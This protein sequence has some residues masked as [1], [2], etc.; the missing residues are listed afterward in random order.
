MNGFIIAIDGHSSCGKS[1]LAR[2]LAGELKDRDFVFIDSGAMYRAVTLYF[3][4]NGIAPGD[5]ERIREALAAIQID[6]LPEAESTRIL[7][8][9]EDVSDAIRQMRVSEK[10][11][12]VSAVREVRHAM[13]ARQ[14]QLGQSR[15]IVMD[16]AATSARPYSRTPI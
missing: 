3:L 4:R 8:N 15:N 13:V 12:E 9:G 1:T 14:Q 16:G 6:F 5:T 2:A 10:V 7:L 11:S